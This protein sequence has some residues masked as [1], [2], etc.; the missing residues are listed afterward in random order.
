MLDLVQENLQPLQ[1]NDRSTIT[2]T[3]WT[4]SLYFQ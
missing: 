1:T 3:V 2:K 4:K